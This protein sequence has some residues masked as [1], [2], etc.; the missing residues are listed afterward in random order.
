VFLNR[1]GAEKGTF[2]T[3][4]AERSGDTAFRPTEDYQKRRGDLRTLSIG[5]NPK[6]VSPQFG[7]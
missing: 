3:A 2:W 5:V 6:E 7:R 4:V 1:R